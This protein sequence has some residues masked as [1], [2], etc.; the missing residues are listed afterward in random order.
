M[1]ESKLHLDFIIIMGR[2]KGQ[3]KKD[4]GHGKGGKQNH[5]KQHKFFKIGGAPEEGG[6]LF[7]VVVVDQNLGCC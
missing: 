6:N 3:G 5:G 2:K 7:G 4:H 1:K